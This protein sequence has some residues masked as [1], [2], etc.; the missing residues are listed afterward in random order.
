MGRLQARAAQFAGRGALIGAALAAVAGCSAIQSA[1]YHLFGPTGPNSGTVAGAG[2]GSVVADEPQAALVGRDVLA[3]GG[4]AADAAAATGLALGVTLPSRASYGGGGVCLVARPGQLGQTVTFTG[5][6]NPMAAPFQGH[7]ERPAMTPMTIRGLYLLQNNF[8]TV[9]F[10]DLLAPAIQ[11]ATHGTTM[12]QALSDD[13]QRVALSFLADEQARSVFTKHG[14]VVLTV[15]DELLQPRLG[16][17]LSRLALTGVGDLYNGAL[18]EVYVNQA[19]NAGA[20]LTRDDMRHALA[21]TEGALEAGVGNAHVSFSGTPNYGGLAAAMSFMRHV[22][23]QSAAAAWAQSRQ[24]GLPAAQAFLTDGSVSPTS[25]PALPAST[26][27]VVTDRKGMAVSCALSENNLFG[28]GRMAGST[29]VVLGASP[30]L[31]PMPLLA[32]AIIHDRQGRLMGALAASGQNDAA[33]AV[34]DAAS[35]MAA[36]QM[37]DMVFQK[38]GAARLNAITCSQ[39]PQNLCT[40]LADPRGH[41][42]A[43]TAGAHAHL[44]RRHPGLGSEDQ[45][46]AHPVTETVAQ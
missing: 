4:N 23:A 11:L 28:T 10:N 13:L 27:F 6:E 37:P 46:L 31:Y 36:G 9:D 40:G 30:R 39:N 41:G 20:G 12:S 24:H 26:S 7:G 38:G 15:G 34:A 42:L 43:S 35:R 16:A 14:N 19:N 8:G 5:L 33:Q 21:H 22:P 3:R 1:R 2:G 29:G 32:S 44:D 18:S 17:F 25:L 45:L